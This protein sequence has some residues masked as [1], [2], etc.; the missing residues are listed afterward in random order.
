MEK[1]GKTL[2]TLAVIVLTGMPTL[3]FVTAIFYREIMPEVFT[4][5][6][7]LALGLIVLGIWYVVIKYLASFWGAS[8]KELQKFWRGY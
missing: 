4:W 3:G 6:T 7:C 2:I 1:L 5:Y 8:P